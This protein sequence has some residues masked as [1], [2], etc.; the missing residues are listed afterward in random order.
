METLSCAELGVLVQ[1]AVTKDSDRFLGG[2]FTA[3][4]AL[5]HGF[6]FRRRHVALVLKAP[7]NAGGIALFLRGGTVV[8]RCLTH[9]PY[10][11]PA[12]PGGRGCKTPSSRNPL[13]PAA[14]DGPRAHH[15]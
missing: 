14:G 2:D 6:R 11:M 4:G 3:R 8:F 9:T 7:N 10:S 12:A 13:L 5:M 1:G 15:N